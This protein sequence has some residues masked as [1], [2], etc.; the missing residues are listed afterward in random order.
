MIRVLVVDD[1]PLVRA[2]LRALIDRTDDLSVTAE[3]E[4]GR[5][6]LQVARE[7]RPD[8]VLMDL[9][10]PVMGGVEAIAAFRA[11]PLLGEVPIV[12]LT[13]FDEDDDVVDAVQAGAAGY[14]LKDVAPEELRQAVRTAA[15]GGSPLAPTVAGRLLSQVAAAPSRRARAELV[16]GLTER[17]LE[18]LTHVGRGLTNEEI[19][20]ALFL[21]PETARTYVSRLLGKLSARDRAQL[22]V[23]AH[24]AGLVD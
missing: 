21:S 9:Q 1:Q 18:I 17:E 3:A 22:V 12:V 19:G 16:E 11:D 4:H 8:V 2:G 24:R 23:I 7:Q 20:R 10:M 6:A 13:T 14:L 15:A 5:Q